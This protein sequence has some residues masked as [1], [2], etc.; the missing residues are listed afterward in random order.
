ME[1]DLFIQKAVSKYSEEAETH[2]WEKI[3]K[4]MNTDRTPLQCMMRWV[5]YI[6]P[7]LQPAKWS[8][9]ETQ[10]LEDL[11]SKLRYDNIIPWAQIAHSLPGFTVSQLQSKWRNI[12]PDYIKGQFTIDDDLK[13]INVIIVYCII[14]FILTIFHFITGTLDLWC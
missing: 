3:A 1:E 4:D 13:L 12:N 6:R 8:N 2:D 5:S 14:D 10:K 11:V 9:E 7:T